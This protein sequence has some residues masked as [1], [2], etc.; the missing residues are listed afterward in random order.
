MTNF[1]GECSNPVRTMAPQRVYAKTNLVTQPITYNETLPL[2][3]AQGDSI[4]QP[5][6]VGMNREQQILQP[7]IQQPPPPNL[8][9][10]R[11][12]GTRTKRVWP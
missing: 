10:M 1:N 3:G 8:E 5:L 6:G 7:F 2:V 12:G 4:P 11:E 9:A